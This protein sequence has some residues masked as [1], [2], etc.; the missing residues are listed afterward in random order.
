MVDLAVDRGL[1]EHLG[2]LLE[3]GG[4]DEDSGRERR[5]GDAEQQRLGD[6]RLACPPPSMRWFSSSKRHFSTCSPIRKSV[7]PTSLMRT[8]RSIWRTIDLDVLV[9]DAHA[10]E[11]VDLLHLVDQVLRELLLAQD[12]EDVVRVRRAVH[13]RLAR[14]HAVALVHADVLALRD[15]VLAR[16]AAPRASRSRGA[17]RACPGRT[18][19]MPSISETTA[20]SFG[21]R[22][23]KSSATRGRPPVMSF[24]LVVSRGI[25][26]I[27]SPAATSSPS[28][29]DEVRADRQVA[30]RAIVSPSVVLDRDARPQLGVLR[31]DDHLRRQ[32]GALVDLLLHGD[33]FDDVAELH[34]AADLGEDRDRVRIPLERSGRPP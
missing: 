20:N 10:L 2:R 23:S 28:S 27:T 11:A 14:A 9:V 32:A 3:R 30:P 21:L 4:R 19:P 25:F 8:R 26:A 33:A 6:R 17:C 12:R 13:E 1:G 31:V 24:V 18:R 16:L 22:A 29:T 7:S 15:Q 5:L 34:R